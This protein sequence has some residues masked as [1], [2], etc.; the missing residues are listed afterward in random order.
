MT[1]GQYG[2]LRLHCERLAPSTPCR[3]PSA[4][5]VRFEITCLG[6]CLLLAAAASPFCFGAQ[7]NL[8]QAAN[9]LWPGE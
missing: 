2:S 1:G 4:Q 9:C 8:D 3:S 5:W 6:G 7:S